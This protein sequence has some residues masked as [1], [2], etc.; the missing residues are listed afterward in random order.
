MMMMMLLSILPRK[1]QRWPGRIEEKGS[2]FYTGGAAMSDGQVTTDH[3]T[4]REWIEERGGVPATV[5]STR[6]GEDAGLLRVD[7]EP[8]DEALEPI[9]W[10]TFFE[11]FDREN[12]AFLYQDRLAEGA[13]SR[14]HKFVNRS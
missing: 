13:T 14:F 10:N 1:E 2:E 5:K 3:D 8:R 4:I 7:F 11:K 12:L 9:D 6:S